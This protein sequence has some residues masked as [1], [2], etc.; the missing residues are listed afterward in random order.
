MKQ[1]ILLF[2]G[3]ICLLFGVN[4]FALESSDLDFLSQVFEYVKTVGGLPWMGKVAGAIALI[5]STMKVSFLRSLWDKLGEAK[6]WAAPVL[7]L[8]AGIFSTSM[9]GEFSW[10]AVSAYVFAGAGA[11]ILHELLDSIKAIP[12]LGTV[13]VTIISIIKGI[14]GAPKEPLV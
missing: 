11:I 10:S 9:N 3:M 2:I 1:S 7:G 8:L 14:L 13:W 5:L 12:K 4:A 6:V